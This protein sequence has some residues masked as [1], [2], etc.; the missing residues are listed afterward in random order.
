METSTEKTDIVELLKQLEEEMKAIKVLGDEDFPVTVNKVRF[1]GM[2]K[3]PGG[4][5]VGTFVSVRPV[6]DNKAKKSFLGV[7][8][9]DMPCS[10]MQ[11]VALDTRD[12][13][14]IIMP[15]SLNP[16][17]FVP[18]LNKIVWGYESWWGQIKSADELREITDEDIQNVWYVKAME[19][20][21]KKE[22][23]NGKA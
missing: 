22:E 8:L 23:S 20:M 17:I 4:L 7:Y 12:G 15:G 6:T 1:N 11:G 16:A 19:Q 14:L 5:A 13:T 3:S 21:A 10:M 18:D 9:G 2:Q